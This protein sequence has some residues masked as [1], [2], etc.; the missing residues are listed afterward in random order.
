[1]DPIVRDLLE[2]IV[3][4]I[5]TIILFIVLAIYLRF[6]FFKPLE[7]VMEERHRQTDGARELA[8][9]ALAAAEE[10]T[11]AFDRALQE[12]RGQIQ[13]DQDVLRQQW[14]A[15]QSATIAKARVDAEAQIKDAQATIAAESD[16]AKAELE[17][18]AATLTE[19]ILTRLL[20]RRAA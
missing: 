2:L 8:Q 17:A 5:P 19:Q 1:M 13:K 16:R 10:K 20:G 14:L 4:S 18:S 12:A 3:K 15:E 11:A 7:K 6:V 9:K